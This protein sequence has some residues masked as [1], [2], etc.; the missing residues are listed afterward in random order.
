L[1]RI[2]IADDHEAVRKGVRAILEM[3]KEPRQFVEA[4]NGKEAVE[5]AQEHKPDLIILDITMPI[6]GGFD[7]ARE[8]KKKLPQVP[9]L[10]LSMHESTQLIEEAKKIGLQGYV[11][12]TQVGA[13]LQLAVDALLRNQNFFPE[14]MPSLEPALRHA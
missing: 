11:T 4:E 3:R 9:V 1:L 6:M 13:T 10:I 2:L 7:A 12:K 14:P 5:K 8:I